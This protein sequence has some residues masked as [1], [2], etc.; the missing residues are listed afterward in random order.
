MLIRPP[1]KDRFF[2][3][4]SPLGVWGGLCG[5]YVKVYLSPRWI[6]GRGRDLDMQFSL[7]HHFEFSG[8]A[9]MTE[10]D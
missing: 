2:L 1:G 3:L 7:A 9:S 5:G 6:M 10:E 8:F 4:Q